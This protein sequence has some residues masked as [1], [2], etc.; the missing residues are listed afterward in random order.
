MQRMARGATRALVDR[1]GARC[2]ASSKMVAKDNLR[3]AILG[4]PASGKGTISSWLVRDFGLAHFS[5]GDELRA[6][7]AQGTD[8][9]EKAKAFIADGKLVPDKLMIDLVVKKLEDFQ[10]KNLLLDGFPRTADQAKAL[11]EAA[12]VDI[13]LNLTVPDEEIKQR[14]EHRRVHIASGRSYHLI[15]NPPKVD[16]VDDETGEPLVQ[17][18]DDTAEAVQA[19]LDAYHAMMS[20]LVDYYN[21]KGV[22]TTFTG[23]ESKVIYP[24]IESFLKNHG[25]LK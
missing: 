1:A 7:I 20:P 24:E 25:Y 13:V 2:F 3:I 6:H 12:E 14:I 22:I 21:S 17:R 4:A 18:P 16:G 19:R 10:G 5:S 11:D 9:G 15:W 23:T 8:L